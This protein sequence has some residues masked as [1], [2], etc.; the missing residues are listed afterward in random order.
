MAVT[1][2]LGPPVLPVSGADR[3]VATVNPDTPPSI[4]WP[5]LVRT[6]DAAWRSL[7]PSQRATVVLYADN[8]GE[9]GAINELGRGTGLRPPSAGKTASGGGGRVT[10]MPPPSWPLRTG[11]A[12][13][14]PATASS[15]ASS[16][17][18]SGWRPRC[19]THTACTTSN[20]TATSI[21]APAL[22]SHGA[23]YGHKCAST[24]D[25]RP[26]HSPD[27][28]LSGQ[29]GTAAIR[30]PDPRPSPRQHNR[31]QP[32]TTHAR[33]APINYHGDEPE[34]H[35]LRATHS[36]SSAIASRADSAIRSLAF[37]NADRTA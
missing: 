19:P 2:P 5:Q 25:S 21:S 31:V 30:R 12:A 23:R 16:S 17:P 29:A 22:A 1:A 3:T 4:G 33:S 10:R 6:V 15:S 27:K 36:A 24:A 13:A 18:A 14:A 35:I 9:A 37:W 20:G 7:P 32:D 34:P 11:P 8:Y 28:R 26:L